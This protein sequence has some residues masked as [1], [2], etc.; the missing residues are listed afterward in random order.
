MSLD[1]N[2]KAKVIKDFG[3]SAND[4]GSVQV[5]IALLTE[6]IKEIASHREKNPKDNSSK[7]GL[8]QAV[9]QRRNYLEYLK[10][11]DLAQYKNILVRLELRK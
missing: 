1:T 6:R 5:Q 7:R 4:T 2:K 9:A 8:L 3:I 10:K 11:H